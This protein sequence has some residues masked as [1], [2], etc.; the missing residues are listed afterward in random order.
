MTRL[1]KG[2]RILACICMTALIGVLA[3]CTEVGGAQSSA[4]DSTGSEA[5]APS[6]SGQATA[7]GESVDGENETTDGAALENGTVPYIDNDTVML[8]TLE[9][10]DPA[11]SVEVNAGEAIEGNEEEELQQERI[12][13][14]AVGEVVSENLEPL[15]GLVDPPEG[16]DTPVYG[17]DG[18]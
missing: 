13:G 7:A 14:G 16:D 12:A 6:E 8:G 2:K 3:A 11:N 17:V 18:Q 10:Y 1:N 4:A 5:A 15:H 9:A